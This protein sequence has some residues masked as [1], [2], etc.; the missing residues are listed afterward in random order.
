MCAN[1]LS[2]SDGTVKN[3]SKWDSVQRNPCRISNSF[4]VVQ[5]PQTSQPIHH[6]KVDTWYSLLSQRHTSCQRWNKKIGCQN[7]I[8]FMSAEKRHTSGAKTHE[9]V[10]IRH[11]F[12]PFAQS[13][14]AILVKI[15]CRPISTPRFSIIYRAFWPEKGRARRKGPCAHLHNTDGW[16]LLGHAELWCVH[17][18]ARKSAA[19]IATTELERVAHRVDSQS[20]S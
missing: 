11:F 7:V 5:K 17:V 19:W 18:C 16:Y 2:N 12:A 10:S 13:G 6:S 3:C 4:D 14:D 1:C 20:A 15:V 9:I 8:A